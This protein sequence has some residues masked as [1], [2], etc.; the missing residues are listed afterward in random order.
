[1]QNRSKASS[2][3]QSEERN[4][5]SALSELLVG[6]CQH[7][8]HHHARDNRNRRRYHHQNVG[9]DISRTLVCGEEVWAP[10]V[11]KLTEQIDDRR[12]TRPLLRRLV[13]SRS[14]PAEDHGVGREAATDVQEGGRVAHGAVHCRDGD[15]EADACD[16]L[17]DGDVP[18]ALAAAVARPSRAK[19]HDRAEKIWRGGEKKGG[20]VVAKV[21]T[22]NDSG[23]EVV[24]T[25]RRVVG[26]QHDNL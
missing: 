23:E 25:V 19:R 6:P 5:L 7:P 21:H 2:F 8:L 20:R 16:A 10:D 17:G 11:S 4:I 18:S 15:D 1:M 3:L 14:G 13:E 9:H 26:G 24:E 12:G 22:T